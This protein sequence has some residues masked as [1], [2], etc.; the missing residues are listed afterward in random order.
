MSRRGIPG[1]QLQCYKFKKSIYRLNK[2]HMA[3]NTKLCGDLSNPGF[4]E[5]PRTPVCFV[6]QVVLAQ[7]VKEGDVIVENLTALYE[8]RV[9]D[10]VELNCSLVCS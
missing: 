9:S 8:L 1:M 4:E 5:F 3:C 10:V 7:T 6:F 2:S